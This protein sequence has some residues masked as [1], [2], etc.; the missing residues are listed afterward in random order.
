MRYSFT[1]HTKI[2]ENEVVF[3]GLH[4]LTLWPQAL[5]Y[6]TGSD[7]TG[8][9]R[10]ESNLQVQLKEGGP[11][12]ERGN[13]IGRK[14]K[15]KWKE[16]SR[17]KPPDQVRLGRRLLRLPRRLTAARGGFGGERASSF[18]L[19]LVASVL[20]AP[21]DPWC[22][23]VA[24]AA[25]A[26]EEDAIDGA[27]GEGMVDLTLEFIDPGGGDLAPD[28]ARESLRHDV[29]H[30]EEYEEE[31]VTALRLFPKEKKKRENNIFRRKRKKRIKKKKKKKRK[32]RKKKNKGSS[33][34]TS[35]SGDNDNGSG[36][37]ETSTS[38][39]GDDDDTSRSYMEGPSLNPTLS[40]STPPSS[41]PTTP[42]TLLTSTMPLT[43]TPT[44]GMS[45]EMKRRS[46]ED[47]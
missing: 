20:L 24:G 40:S 19:L 27:W 3:A 46:L 29:D 5:R 37:S 34:I 14:E 22:C 16:E 28:M 25:T 30:E 44:I 7:R 18:L 4:D 32:K 36:S 6:R 31:T 9:G 23:L 12:S 47:R 11:E 15:E 13:M 42:P 8:P 45:V 33:S 35:S 38:D 1:P 21:L 39:E 2:I 26:N 43:Q 41:S 17:V 10:I